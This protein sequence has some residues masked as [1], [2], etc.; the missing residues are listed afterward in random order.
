MSQLSPQLAAALR[1]ERPLLYG[2]VEINLP[3]HDLLLVDGAA[4]LMIGNRKFVGRDPVYGALDTIKGLTDSVGEKAPVVSLGLIPSSATAL[5]ALVDPAVQGS[6]VTISIGCVD[7]VTG[8]AVPHAYV[9]FAGELDVPTITWDARDRRLEYRIGSV[10]ERLF[11]VE[12]ALRLCLAWHQSVW[13]GELGLEFV[14][15]VETYVPWGQKIDLT[16]VETRTNNAA[17]GRITRDR[18]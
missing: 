12:E 16:A 13:P 9:L 1:G 7:M 11:A 6:P 5:A 8:L 4:E 17:L 3:G 15:E 10:A 18:T 2:S 14:S